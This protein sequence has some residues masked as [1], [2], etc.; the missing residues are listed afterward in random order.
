MMANGERVLSR[1][2]L[3]RA[4]LDRQLLN[5][6]AEFSVEEALEHLVGLQSQQPNPPYFGLWSRLESFDPDDLVQPLLQRNVVRA[7]LMRCT[8]HV[9]TAG[10]CLFLRRSI[11]RVI[12]RQLRGNPT[13]AAELK[14]L[15][16]LDD[17]TQTAHE[18]L[19]EPRDSKELGAHL[20]ARWPQCKP[21][22]DSKSVIVAVVA[23]QAIPM[24]SSGRVKHS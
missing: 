19:R 2:E 3:N 8:V 23:G 17:L 7:T 16:D 12:D 9:V 5:R 21:R 6:R 20:A 13:R 10:D 14:K 24:R 1:R 4:L 15:P 11:A 18:F 22:A